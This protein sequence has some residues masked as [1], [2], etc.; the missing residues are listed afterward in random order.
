[1]HRYAVAHI[2]TGCA[3]SSATARRLARDC[4][5][6][7]IVVVAAIAAAAAAIIAANV[8]EQVV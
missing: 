7:H 2:T 5:R 8:P 3:G 4:V 6:G 1:M